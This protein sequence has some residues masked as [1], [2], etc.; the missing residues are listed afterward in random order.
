MNTFKI[1]LRLCG[2]S[3]H[4]LAFH[5]KVPPQIG[6]RLAALGDSE[7][8]V[9]RSSRRWVALQ[10]RQ[11][12]MADE[13]IA[14]WEKAGRPPAISYAAAKDNQEA[15][16]IG[17]PSAAAQ[18]A[19]AAIAQGVLARLKSDWMKAVRTSPASRR[20]KLMAISPSKRMTSVVF[21]RCFRRSGYSELFSVVGRLE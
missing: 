17:W 20:N 2:L 6:E 9:C 16:S 13:I 21:G 19:P 5:L 10:A 18:V 1:L 14:T 3:P 12:E 11:Q 15:R 4:D 8:P 7:P